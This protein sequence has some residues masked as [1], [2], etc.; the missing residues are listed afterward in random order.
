MQ[1][2]K[3]IASRERPA[4]FAA[5]FDQFQVECKQFSEE[6]EVFGNSL[7]AAVATATGAVAAALWAGGSFAT[8]ALA[9]SPTDG[10]IYVRRS[11]GGASPT[12]PKLDPTNWRMAAMQMPT[13][14][15]VSA[16]T[17]TIEPFTAIEMSNAAK[18]TVTFPASPAVDDWFFLGVQ[19]ALFNNEV[20]PGALNIQGQPGNRY[21]WRRM[22]CIWRYVSVAY[23][24]RPYL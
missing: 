12:D 2:I 15:I 9:R 13:T 23:G 18:V 1:A 8:G 5:D 10:L 24:W 6:A 20:N 17:H 14:Q 3:T 21:L 22:G 4:T 7:S 11:P 16:T 19:N